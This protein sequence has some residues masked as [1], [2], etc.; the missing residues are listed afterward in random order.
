MRLLSE[1]GKF[2]AECSFMD[3]KLLKKLRC[4]WLPKDSRWAIPDAYIAYELLCHYGAKE[5]VESDIK[6]AYALY[7]KRLKLSDDVYSDFTVELPKNRSLYAYQKAGVEYM[8]E[9]PRVLLADDMGLGK[10]AQAIA[11]CNLVKPERILV[12]CPASL[13]I[14]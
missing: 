6:K 11:L 2:Y 1:K 8:I 7:S 12:V 9:T 4:V 13:K 5:S 14:N 3:A 10:T